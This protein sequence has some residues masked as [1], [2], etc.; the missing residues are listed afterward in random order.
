MVHCV[1]GEISVSRLSSLSRK[2]PDPPWSL[3]AF[4]FPGGL[5]LGS[6]FQFPHSRMAHLRPNW[7]QIAKASPTPEIGFVFSNSPLRPTCPGQMGLF[8]Q[9]PLSPPASH[10]ASGS[11]FQPASAHQKWLRSVKTS[12]SPN[13]GSVFLN[14]RLKTQLASKRKSRPRPLGS[15]FQPTSP[16]PN[17]LRSVIRPHTPTVGRTT[18]AFSSLPLRKITPPTNPVVPRPKPTLCYSIS[19][20]GCK[21]NWAP[22][23]QV[24]PDRV[25]GKLLSVA[26]RARQPKSG[27]SSGPK[28]PALVNLSHSQTQGSNRRQKK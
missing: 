1:C 18:I 13:F 12:S 5:K 2:A 6:F 7:L 3:G 9:K 22:A 27:F 24:T 23:L 10:T 14:P 26:H 4:P 28:R 17:W 16:R 21:L 15:F 20:T 11:F 25:P 8:F 19:S